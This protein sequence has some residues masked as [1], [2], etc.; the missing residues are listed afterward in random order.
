MSTVTSIL[1]KVDFSQSTTNCCALI[2]PAD[3]DEKDFN[4]K[5]RR[6]VK[7]RSRSILHV[8]LNIGPVMKE[9]QAKIDN[10]NARAESQLILSDE[11]SPWHADHYIE[12]TRD[13]PNME[14]TTLPGE[15][16]TR[17]FEGPY[18]NASKWQRQLMQYAENEGGT[19]IKTY[20]F[21]TVCPKC[22]KAYGKKYVVGF[23][24]IN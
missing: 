15:Y 23:E 3:W 13:V 9:A 5:D 10:V 1:P 19:P 8:P 11:A 2:N 17:V 21:Y 14:M 18:R 20:F 4:F 12:T 22:A 7:V 24:Q 16:L 6:F